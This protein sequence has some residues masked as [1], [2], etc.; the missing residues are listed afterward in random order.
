MN[1]NEF[2][3]RI[4]S[5]QPRVVLIGTG[6]LLAISAILSFRI[7]FSYQFDDFFPKADD[8]LA[9]FYEY[10]E[11]FAPDD[12]F[13]LVGF[14]PERLFDPEFLKQLDSATYA[15]NRLPSVQRA[16]SLPS[17][18]Y[19][20]KSPFGYLSYPAI[21][22]NEPERLAEDSI[23]LRGDERVA[24]KLV[25]EDFSTTIVFIQ[26]E[27]SLNQD[28]NKAL[29]SGVEFI[30]DEQGLSGFHMIGKSYFEV[31]LVAFQKKEFITFSMLSLLCVTLVMF[32]LF[33][34]RYAVIIAL[35]TVMVCLGIFLGFLGATGTTLNVM[36]SLFPIIIIIVGI[37]DVVH[38]MTRYVAELR[39]GYNR[40]T[41]LFMTLRDVGS[42]TFLTSV[43]TAIGF[44]TLITSK[45][46]PIREFGLLAACGVLLAY[47]VALFFTAP[48]LL[49]FDDQKLAS[50][51]RKRFNWE[52]YLLGVYHTGKAKP[53]R[54]V[55]VSIL[56]VA[57]G[58]Y[59]ISRI[60]TD[61]SLSG[62]LPADSKVY[63][64]FL[65]FE[66]QFNG[67]R[68]LEIAAMAQPGYKVTD[69]EVLREIDRMETFTGKFDIING[70]QSLTLFYKSL[71]RASNGDKASA[72]KLP[73]T[74]EA[75]EVLHRDLD[76]YAEREM[77]QFVTE[78][79]SWGRMNGFISDAGTDS[80]NKVQEAMMDF[81]SH[82]LD[83]N[84]VQ[85]KITGT[86]VI[87]DKNNVY[88]RESILFGILI[89]LGAISLLMGGL[90]KDL[91]LLIIAII[92]N[93]IP[94]IICGSL[95]GFLNLT[96]DAPTAIIFGI[97]Y[98]IVV[99][100]TIHFLSRFKIE[101]DKGTPLELSIQK[102][103]VETGKAIIITSLILFFGFSVLMLSSL[104]ATSNVGLLIG[105]TL[106][107]A[108]IAD[109]YLLPLLLR[110]W[111]KDT[112]DN[113]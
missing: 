27:D 3:R 52:K 12:N 30:M 46:P 53:A 102:T 48:L 96:L 8:D 45:I 43:T 32:L 5:L 54:I 51:N 31:E 11:K 64:D 89:A 74:D 17:Y 95:L 29:L 82:S 106:L 72:Y 78:D 73:E 44:L 58:L 36:S 34:N 68:P 94:L 21:H 19:L 33:R 16:V 14:Q 13:L 62:S 76:R 6:L 7:G 70:M 88:I 22:Y 20:L 24:G 67:F 85:F 9:F 87:F 59:G 104:Q 47:L 100:D 71:N 111:L 23:R 66:E 110:N 103:F 1:L 63:D 4:S 113:S 98:G 112:P 81:A 38:F 49:L 91:R 65:F 37:S 109:L 40:R 15:I 69:P 10:K 56:V 60:T 26:T 90:Y 99:D 86:G 25:S 61:I 41:A 77:S 50:R 39:A 97:S 80:I 84:L 101:R 42:A 79:L 83:T 28:Q 75:F 55:M 105:V 35:A 93:S 107:T 108:V 2:W 18:K 92:P 57:T